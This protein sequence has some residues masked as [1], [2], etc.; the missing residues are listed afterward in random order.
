MIS[1]KEF[2]K[3]IDRLK[4]MNAKLEK[5][6][7]VSRDLGIGI[8]EIIE[9]VPDSL[10]EMLCINCGVDPDEKYG[11]IISWWIYDT[12]YGSD[13]KLNKVTV[14]KK[15]YKL[16]TAEDLYDFIKENYNV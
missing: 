8:I 1:K 12:K 2:I 7:L 10:I 16:K 6:S 15:I 5:L 13:N 9:W 11:D 4:Q 14:G 3:H